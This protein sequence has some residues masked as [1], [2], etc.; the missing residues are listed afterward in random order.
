MNFLLY[1]V[2]CCK[3]SFTYQS[4]GLLFVK[5]PNGLLALKNLVVFVLTI[6]RLFR[7]WW[8]QQ[9]LD[10]NLRKLNRSEIQDSSFQGVEKLPQRNPLITVKPSSLQQLLLIFL[11]YI[12]P[13]SLNFFLNSFAT[14]TF[15]HTN[16]SKI[17]GLFIVK[18]QQ[19][20]QSFA[21]YQAG[22]SRVTDPYPLAID[23]SYFSTN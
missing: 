21:F 16:A 22:V 10:L 4:V 1:S 5:Q 6:Q 11:H 2:R 18:L 15:W 23:S 3:R 13:W 7:N 12:F 20:Y 14:N 17:C 9:K 8:Q 19:F